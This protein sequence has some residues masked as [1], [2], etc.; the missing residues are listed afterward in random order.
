MNSLK[1]TGVSF[2]WNF[3]EKFQ[4]RATRTAIATQKTRLFTVEFNVASRRLY[5]LRVKTTTLAERGHPKGF[6]HH[7]SRDPGDTLPGSSTTGTGSRSSRG[8]FRST[9]HPVPSYDRRGQGVAPDHQG[10]VSM[11]RCRPSAAA[12]STT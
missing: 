10:A 12:S 2:R 1:L 4:T 6:A 8:T 7:V 11:V 5:R 3:E 9:T